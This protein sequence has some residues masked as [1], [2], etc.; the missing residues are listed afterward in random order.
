MVSRRAGC[1]L[2]QLRSRRSLGSTSTTEMFIQGQPVDPQ[3]GLS[4]WV[5]SVSPEFFET[6]KIPLVSGRGFESRDLVQGCSS[7][8]RHQRTVARKYFTG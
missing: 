8:R 6:F 3:K 7:C 1:P 5:M 4:L 2:G